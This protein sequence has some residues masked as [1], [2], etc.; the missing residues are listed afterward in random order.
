MQSHLCMEST[1]IYGM[2]LACY[3][4][5]RHLLVS[6]VNPFIIK[7][8]GQ[9]E[10]SRNKTD[11][12]DAHLIARFCMSKQ[13]RPWSPPSPTAVRLRS[14]TS[15]HQDLQED[16]TRIICRIEAASDEEARTF[17]KGRLSELES[18]V[19][20]IQKQLRD[21]RRTD[22]ELGPS[23]PFV[24]LDSRHRRNDGVGTFGRDPGHPGLSKCQA[25][26]RLCRA[27]TSQPII[28]QLRQ[29]AATAIEEG[30]FYLRQNPF[31]ARDHVR[32]P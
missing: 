12:A 22:S 5:D 9:S 13:P 32:S 1:G 8:F 29:E 7:A 16:R 25:A 30:E 4:H 18:T 27:H 28:R 2:G 10:L 26:C 31:P 11:R 20:A 23:V 17:W 6:V 19:K 21:F 15:R 3:L 24:D 14:L